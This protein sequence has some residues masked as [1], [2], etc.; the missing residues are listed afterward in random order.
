VS[1]SL[2]ETVTVGASASLYWTVAP[3]AGASFD[4]SGAAWMVKSASVRSK[5]MFPTASILIRPSAHPPLCHTVE[6]TLAESG[7]AGH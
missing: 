5:K 3:P 2:A 4:S 7:R 1:A 6:Q